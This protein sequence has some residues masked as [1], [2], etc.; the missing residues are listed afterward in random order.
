MRNAHRILVGIPE[1]KRSCGALKHSLQERMILKRIWKRLSMQMWT[2]F[3]W[4]DIGSG[5]GLS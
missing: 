2:G 5:S 1:D 4:F 3:I